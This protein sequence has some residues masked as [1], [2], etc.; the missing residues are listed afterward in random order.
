MIIFGAGCIIGAFIG[1]KICDKLRI[2]ISSIIGMALLYL[3][4][5]FSIVASEIQKLWSA[6]LD[7]FLLGFVMYYIS[8]N[9]MVI[10]SRLYKGRS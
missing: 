1:G 4:C 8:A 7:C 3:S 10:C 6:R 9:L 5:L 2:K